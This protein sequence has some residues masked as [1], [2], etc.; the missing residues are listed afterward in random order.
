MRFFICIILASH[1]LGRSPCVVLV[2]CQCYVYNIVTY[3]YNN[4]YLYIFSCHSSPIGDLVHTVGTHHY[5][6][7]LPIQEVVSIKSIMFA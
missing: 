6:P 5:F 3:L 1:F 2:F 4:L 7:V